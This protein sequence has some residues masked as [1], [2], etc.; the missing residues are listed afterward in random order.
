MAQYPTF[1]D[2]DQHRT[3]QNASNAIPASARVEVS[4]FIPSHP[5]AQLEQKEKKTWLLGS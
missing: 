1:N 5:I 2:F 3:K 4:I